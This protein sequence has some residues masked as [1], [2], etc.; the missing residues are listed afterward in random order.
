[1]LVKIRYEKTKIAAS[2]N[3]SGL[4]ITYL[5]C[6]NHESEHKQKRRHRM[7]ELIGTFKRSANHL[8]PEAERQFAKLTHVQ[9][10]QHTS[11]PSLSRV[12]TSSTRERI[13][14]STTHQHIHKINRSTHINTSTYQHIRTSTHQHS[15]QH[16][17]TAT[18]CHQHINT[19]TQSPTN[20]STTTTQQHVRQ[21]INTL[22]RQHATLRQS[23]TQCHQHITCSLAL[24][25]FSLS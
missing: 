20:T 19:S 14:T 1:L 24:R 10:Q 15:H 7:C 13:D 17:N 22:T 2:V 11:T 8:S 18:Q 6:T 3:V 21:H 5:S 12:T 4:K 16:I 23:S 25:G 9:G